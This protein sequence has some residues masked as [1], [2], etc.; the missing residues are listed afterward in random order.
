MSA[1]SVASS[2]GGSF[3]STSSAAPAS[4]PGVQRLQQ[5]RL[6]HDAATRAVDDA[7][8][9]L[10]LGQ[11][12]RA[13]QSARPC[14]QRR[15]DRQE[16]GLWQQLFQRHQ[17]DVELAR[18]LRRGVGIGGDQAHAQP[19][20]AS[21]ARDLRANLAQSDDAERLAAHLRADEL[22]ALPASGAQRGVGRSD[23]PRQREQQCDGMLGGG[24]DVAQ[25]RVDD[26]DATAA[27]PP[28][29]RCY[30]RR[31]PRAR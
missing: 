25:R 8:R 13:E 18:G 29:R 4:L 10:E 31:R 26:D 24:V 16:V 9:R 14:G 21:P 15:M 30:P 23:V 3:V 28:P 2:P 19:T 5:R 6:V 7:R 20:V 27:S 12:L 1:W 22:R 17:L 11:L